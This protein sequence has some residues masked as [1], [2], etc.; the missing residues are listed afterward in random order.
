MTLPEYGYGRMGRDGTLYQVAQW[1]PRVAVF[2]DVSGWNL[3]PFLGAGE[4]Y[5]EYGDFQVAVT[6]PDNFVMT[7]TGTIVNPDAVLTADQRAR[8]ARA[9]ASEAVV[10]IITESEARANP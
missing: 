10:A 4:F 6:V 2:D 3:T 5:Q 8:L 9:D 1:Y 7:A